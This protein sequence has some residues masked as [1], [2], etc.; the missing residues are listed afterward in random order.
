MATIETGVTVGWADVFGTEQLL[1]P[2]GR[3]CRLEYCS[4]CRK[5]DSLIDAESWIC[6]RQLDGL[7]GGAR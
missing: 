7:N 5:Q 6:R 1:A 4:T 2:Q 3:P